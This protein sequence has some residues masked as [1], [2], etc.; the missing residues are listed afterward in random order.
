MDHVILFD[1]ICNFC[2]RAVNWIIAHDRDAK[3]KFAP[4][5]GECG[6]RMRRTFGITND[7]DSIILI[8]DNRAY[9]HSSAALRI[10]KTLGGIWSLGYA[11]IVIPQ[12]IRDWFYEWFARNRYRWFGKQEACMI[13]APEVRERFVK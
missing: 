1:G 9:T 6:T 10:A 13:P 8:E 7:V 4:L 5:Q 11:A 2:N 12:P 3:F